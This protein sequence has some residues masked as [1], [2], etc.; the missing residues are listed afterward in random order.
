MKF[1]LAARYTRY[2]EMQK[3]RADLAR[4]GHVVT[5]RWIEGT[6]VDK[7]N[8]DIANIDT[9]D[10]EMAECVISFTEMPRAPVEGATRGGRHVEF[11]MALALGKRVIVVGYRENVFHSR[12][13]V[14]FF[15]TWG[16]C[17]D[18]LSRTP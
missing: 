14:E 8:H 7:P 6:D 4:L 17:L 2:P 16:A 15:E 18:F 5:S 10:L 12:A 3:V 1:Y 9:A 11:G 13:E